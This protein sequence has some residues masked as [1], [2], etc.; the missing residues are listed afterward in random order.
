MKIVSDWK[1]F[2]TFII[3]VA[4]VVVPVWLWQIDLSSKSLSIKLVTHTSLQPKEQNSLPEFEIFFDGSRLK[5]PHFAIFEIKND[6]SKPILAADFESPIE[7]R[8]DSETSFIRS[9]ITDVNPKDIEAIILSESKR[10]L[11]KPIL[12]NS[13]DTI[14]INAITSGEPPAFGYKARV[15]GIPNVSVEDNASKKP[16][17]AKL[18]LLLLGSV[19]SFSALA[20]VIDAVTD[21]KKIFFRPRAAAFVGIVSIFPGVGA[22]EKFLE[23]IGI[24]GL[25]YLIACYLLL[26]IPAAFIASIINRKHLSPRQAQETNNSK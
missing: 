2:L 10:I 22:L 3:A 11:L 14:T 12:L 1:F 6:G 25:W 8:L 13:K 16:N 26:S 15:A 4:G 17:K 18:A 5:N 7:I 20:I 21:F 9:Q 19:L 24:V 23:G